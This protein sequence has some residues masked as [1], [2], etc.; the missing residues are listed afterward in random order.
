MT[1]LPYVP[2]GAPQQLT[3]SGFEQYSQRGIPV[4]S[5]LSVGNDLNLNKDR[6]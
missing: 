6:T 2:S 1:F 3:A 5:N 4:G